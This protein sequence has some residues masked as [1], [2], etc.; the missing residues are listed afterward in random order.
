MFPYIA[1][2]YTNV[3]LQKKNNIFM[4]LE[5]IMKAV[6]NLFESYHETV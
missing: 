3:F 1:Q 2:M 6:D 4:T 5:R